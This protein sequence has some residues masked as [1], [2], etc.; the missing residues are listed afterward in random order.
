MTDS[1]FRIVVALDLTEYSSLVLEHALDQAVR[2]SAPDLH[3]LS[4]VD[5]TD[6]IEPTKKRLAELVLPSLDAIDRARWS[7]RLHVRAGKTAE[8]IAALAGEIGARLIVIGRFGVHHPHRHLAKTASDILDLAPCPVF[9]A[10]FA[11]DAVQTSPI[12]PDCA[13]V[14]TESE[15]ERW[16]CERHRS[17]RV[18]TR[19]PFGSNFTGSNQL[20]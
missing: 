13:K 20:W 9:V 12:C 4:V 14:R 17:D 3:F 6:A 5:D 15:G 10:A 7:V 8:E 11:E 19:V 18:S 16:F 1:T 2:H